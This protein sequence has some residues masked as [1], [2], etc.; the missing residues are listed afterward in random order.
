M[1]T[2]R[3]IVFDCDGVLWSG[4]NDGYF[5]CYYQAA[6]EAGVEIDYD[7]ACQRLLK[8]WGQS[9]QRE[10]EGMLPEHP[11]AV[12]DVL[13]RYE[14]LVRSDLFLST[15]R[16]IPGAEATLRHLASRYRLSAITGMNSD[17]LHSLLARFQLGDCFVHALS[18]SETNDPA[19]QKPTGYHLRCVLDAERLRPDE[20]LCVGDAESD[21]AMARRQGVPI[22][23][24][25]TG[26]IT[27]ASARRLKVPYLPSVAD[28]P[29][30][31]AANYRQCAA[32]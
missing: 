25:L 1:T 28:L 10:I 14:R 20:A 29:D 5:R 15:A 23:A 11:Q 22:V 9:A 24:V 8:N 7:L 16:L 32:E 26:H 2:L 18:T 27:E 21:V 19:K 3:H 6:V 12:A 17:N 4:T 31:L 30:W 13:A